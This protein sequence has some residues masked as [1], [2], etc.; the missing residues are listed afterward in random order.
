MTSDMVL[1]AGID[2]VVATHR[3][4]NVSGVP[5]AA[6]GRPE[7]SKEFARRV[8]DQFVLRGPRERTEGGSGSVETPTTSTLPVAGTDNSDVRSNQ[9]GTHVDLVNSDVRS[10]QQRTHPDANHT[11]QSITEAIPELIPDTSLITVLGSDAGID[12]LK[13]L[14]GHYQDDPMFRSILDKPKDFRN[15]EVKDDLIY[16]KMNGHNLLCIPK[17]T[18]N[19]RNVYEIIISE[20]HSMLAHLGAS[21]TV[22]YLRD[23][24][25]WKDLVSDTKAYCDTCVTCKRSKP[26][27]QKPYGLLNPLAIPSEPWESIGVDF[28]G[29][30]PLSIN[31]DGEFD[32]ITVV[33]CLLTAMVEIIP[34][35]TNYKA[36]DIAELMFEHVYKHHG[37]PKTIISDRDV[38]F[39]STFWKHLNTL[40]GI[41]LKM[42]SA[43][44]PQTDGTTERAN[45]TITQ[46]LRQCINPNQ[47]DWVSKLPTIQFAINSAR[48]EST[49]YAPF[50]LNNGRMPRTMVWNAASS[51]EYSNV[52]EFAQK[53]KLALMSAH[54]SILSARIKQ[55]RDANRR[56]QLVPFK[57]GD[58]V[59]LS[60]KNITFAKGLA[61]KLIPKYI[62]PYQILQ[63]FNNQSFRLDLPMHLKKRGV[64]DVFHS[65]LLRI[66]APNDDRLFPGRMDTQIGD[67]PDTEDEWAVELIRSHAGS[68]ENSIFEILWKSGDVTWM[69]YYQIRHL[70]ALD[71]YL[72][73]MG[74]DSASKLATGKGKPPQEDPQVFIGAVTLCPPLL[75]PSQHSLSPASDSL[76]S[77]HA[78][79]DPFSSQPLDIKPFDI[80]SCSS[81]PTLL[82][83]FDL[84]SSTS[85]T[86]IDML[87]SI[88]HQRFFR[89][90]KTDYLM[91]DP[92]AKH[93]SIIH[94]GQI[95][96]YLTFDKLLRD[97]RPL[98]K[99]R[100]I[101]AG[102]ATF[103]TV[104]NSG[105]HY[106]DK[107]RLSTFVFTPTG[108]QVVRSTNPVTLHDFAITAEQ[109][110]LI[111]PRRESVTT[112]L[113]HAH[114]CS[115]NLPPL[116][117]NNSSA[118]VMPV[119]NE[120]IDARP[121]LNLIMLIP[122]N[123]EI[124]NDDN[125]T[126]NQSR[127]TSIGAL[128]QFLRALLALAPQ[129][130]TGMISIS[131]PHTHPALL[132]VNI[133]AANI[134]NRQH[135]PVKSLSTTRHRTKLIQSL[136]ILLRSTFQIQTQPP[137]LDFSMM[138]PTRRLRT[139]IFPHNP[140]PWRSKQIYY[141]GITSGM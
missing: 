64:H 86:L 47:K 45:R 121:R 39:T 71:T 107:R 50:F 127:F 114:M 24:V 116:W 56:R 37:L 55:T 84:K 92:V 54:N 105:T 32:S 75:F 67:G 93:R 29:P 69:P 43:Y 97:G 19:G 112:T 65:S 8:R 120:G 119:R 89:L 103:A 20:A 73:L 4:S 38:L 44:H 12:L 5:D 74:V 41:K 130:S 95:S 62:G 80:S 81:T 77:K 13:E 123:I 49:G 31:R 27:N 14:K 128:P 28:V 11:D 66:H 30:L 70:Q 134:P 132:P 124:V 113:K 131:L 133:T 1:L 83:L 7:T 79:T 10:N 126:P 36:Q 72:E 23:H 57:E 60:T 17:T 85:P 108:D 100:G 16:L 96:A 58:L 2:A 138:S 22:N 98:D 48:S 88:R 94:V 6:T 129:L 110:G 91:S 25:W 90:S 40:I 106:N 53:R 135:P 102:Y 63:D 18:I 104:F 101:P 118:T 59:Y 99:M 3:D 76:P 141:L 140:K 68:R 139:A 122:R 117:L 35:R 125:H 33:I 42:S 9:R 109:C 21:K 78:N 51:T 34:S 136:L 52:R 61:R 26:N 111:N 115:R 87:D 82:D 137:F 15:F 46:M